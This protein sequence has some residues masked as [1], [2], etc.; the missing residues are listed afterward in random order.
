[1]DHPRPF[2]HFQSLKQSMQSLQQINVKNLHP[3]SGG[4]WHSNSRP[5]EHQSYPITTTRGLSPKSV[6]DPLTLLMGRGR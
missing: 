5:L 4:C 2:V 6:Y 1:M 3:E